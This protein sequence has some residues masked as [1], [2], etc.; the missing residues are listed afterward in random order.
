ME[1]EYARCRRGGHPAAVLMLDLDHF[2]AINDTH[3]HPV[4]DTVLREVAEILRNALRAQDLPGRYGGEEFG[5][6]LPGSGTRRGHGDRR[7]HPQ[8]PGGGVD[9]AQARPARDGEH[10]LRGARRE[11]QRS[12]GLDRARRP[13]PLPGEGGGAQPLDLR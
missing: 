1:R 11:R 4:G 6:L 7:A 10:R 2:K 8:A 3:G 12:R 9:R 5:V 13:R